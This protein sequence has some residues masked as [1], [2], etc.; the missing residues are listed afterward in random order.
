MD[1]AFYDARTG[2][3]PDY[4]QRILA[5]A[6][7]SI[8]IWDT[9]FRPNEDWKVFKEVKTPNISITILTICDEKYNTNDD[10][11]VLANNIIKNLNGAD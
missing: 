4:Y 5:T 8:Q 2:L 1:Y 3:T 10:V 9:H 7:N 6:T 11:R